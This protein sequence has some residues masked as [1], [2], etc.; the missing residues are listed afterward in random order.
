[1]DL[2]RCLRAPGAV[3]PGVPVG[4]A[5][6]TVVTPG[7]TVGGAGGPVVLIAASAGPTGSSATSRPGPTTTGPGAV[8]TIDGGPNATAHIVGAQTDATDFFGLGVALVVIVGAVFLT[9]LLFRRRRDE[10]PA[11]GMR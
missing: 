11:E 3:T 9:R 8:I 7:V 5:G 10:P 4:G 1:M 2:R 6:V